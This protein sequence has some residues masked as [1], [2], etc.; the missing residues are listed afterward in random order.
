MA[1][2]RVKLLVRD[3]HKHLR[4]NGKAFRYEDTADVSRV[5]TFWAEIYPLTNNA[6]QHDPHPERT[7]EV[8]LLTLK[9]YF[10]SSLSDYLPGPRM[11]PQE[12]HVV[13]SADGMWSYTIGRVDPHPQD[14]FIV[15]TI[16][17][18]VPLRSIRA[19]VR[20]TTNLQTTVTVA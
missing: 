16:A 4:R 3:T 12:Q 14:P 20:A 6:V 11:L 15:F 19:S 9:W 17:R 7:P 1:L 10:G 8:K 18:S 2:D 13:T 5:V